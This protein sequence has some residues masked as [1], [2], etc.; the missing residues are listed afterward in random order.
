MTAE[1][2]MLSRKLLEIEFGPPPYYVEFD[3][4]I[5]K[6]TVEGGKL[7]F[8][9][10]DPELMPY[11]MYFFMRK[12][13]EGAWDNCG[14]SINLG[15]VYPEPALGSSMC[16]TDKFKGPDGNIETLAF[17]EYSEKV[18]HDVLTL[19]ISG[20]PGGLGVYISGQDNT[21]PLGPKGEREAGDP[22]LDADPTIGKLVQGEDLFIR[23]KRICKEASLDGTPG[24]RL[25][26][27]IG[28]FLQY[29]RI[30]TARVVP[31][32]SVVLAV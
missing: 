12:V 25:F 24:D 4:V 21:K 8:E 18:P 17:Q 11:S 16:N 22:P 7:S 13:K 14:F 19:G 29:V 30:G 9:M 3:V 32:S 5:D 1:L 28:G 31:K 6:Y 20:R 23:L 26:L 15:V 2:K 27:D 10:A